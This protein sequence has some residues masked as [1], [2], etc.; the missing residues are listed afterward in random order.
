A[1]G[2]QALDSAVMS[3]QSG[4]SD[5][6]LAGGTDALSRASVMLQPDMAAWLGRWNKARTIKERAG[7]FRTLKSRHLKPVIGLLVGLTD[8]VVGLSMGQTAES[9]AHEFGITRSQMDEYAARSHVLTRRAQE[10]HVLD[11]EI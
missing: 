1:S 10:R 6:V 4:R 3:I 11:T 5:L 7:V 9:L 8:P 2:M